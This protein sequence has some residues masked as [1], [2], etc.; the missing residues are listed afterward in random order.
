MQLSNLSRGGLRSAFVLILV[1]AVSALFLAVTWTFLKPLLVGALLAGFARPLYRWISKR[2]KGHNSLAAGLTVLIVFILLVGPLGA[3]IGVVVQQAI[4]V[5]NDALPWLEKNI[6]TASA[7]NAHDWIVH[8]YPSLAAYVPTQQEIAENASRVAKTAAGY[9]VGLL[10]QFTA[11]TAGFLLDFFVMLYS[12]FFFLRDGRTI[13]SKIFYYTPLD[14][15]DEVRLLE[16][17]VSVTRATIKG[18]IVI[19][20]IQGA[21]A[22]LGLWFAGI[23]GAA[24]WATVMAVLS[25]LPGIGS[26]IVWLP[27]VI[28]LFILGKAWTAT[29]LLLWCA[30]GV[31]TIDNL[32]RPRLVGKDAQMPDLLILIGTL[33][34]VFVFGPIGFIIGPLICGLFLTVW[35]IYGTTFKDVLPPV[36]EFEPAEPKPTP[37]APAAGES[38][39]SKSL[40]TE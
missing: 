32:I 13:L 33:G 5:T 39:R 30:A 16:R 38:S 31:G 2:L 19:G 8:R 1:L 23:E 11:G 7:F 24:F 20:A 35:E 25:V 6:S 9:L 36:L 14:H 27:A 40:E 15:K 18:T 29:L 4:G 17:F 34:G 12:L 37:V 21:L 28:Y 3:F 22:G 26:A 10:T